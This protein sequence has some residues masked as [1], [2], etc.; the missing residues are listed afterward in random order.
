MKAQ[1]P[2]PEHYSYLV[3]RKQRNTQVILPVV[4]SALLMIGMIVLISF[5]TFKSGGDVGRWAAISTIWIII[6]LLITGLIV[7]ALLIGGIYLMARALS[8]L[9]YYT[10]IAQD[11]VHK[12]R[13]YITRGADMAAK[14]ILAINDLVENLKAF[15]GRIS[16]S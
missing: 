5:A 15:F 10:G 13:G 3:H 2:H 16:N 1:L 9:P 6:P 14:P 12:A 8:G 11:Y 7:L 4:L